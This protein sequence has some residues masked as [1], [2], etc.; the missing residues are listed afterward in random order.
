MLNCVDFC[1]KASKETSLQ[2]LKKNAL[3]QLTYLEVD[4]TKL[5]KY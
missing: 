5:T 2:I 3:K 4:K 1:S